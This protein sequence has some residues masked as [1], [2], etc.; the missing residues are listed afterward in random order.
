MR[1][2]SLSMGPTNSYPRSIR[3]VALVGLLTWAHRFRWSELRG[4]ARGSHSQLIWLGP[5][6]LP[7]HVVTNPALGRLRL[8]FRTWLGPLG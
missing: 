2:G 6:G 3:R 5:G 7:Y 4:G 8:D 1:L